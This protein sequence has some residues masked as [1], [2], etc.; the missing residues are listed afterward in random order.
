MNNKLVYTSTDLSI[1][2]QIITGIFGIHGLFQ[3]LEPIHQILKTV[4]GL[5]MIVQ[6]VELFFYIMIIRNLPVS[7][8]AYVRYYDWFFTT[9]A[10]LITT[11]IYF[12]YEQY[13]E[14]FKNSKNSNNSILLKS[15]LS[16]MNLFDFLKENKL[17][18][19]TIVIC[20]FFM[21]L[22]GY[23]GE[24]GAADTFISCVFGFAFF[25]MAFYVIYDKFAKFSKIGNKMFK[26]LFFVWSLYGIA[27]L[28][29][30]IYKN[31]SFNTLDVVSKNFFG[32][33]LYFKILEKK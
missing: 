21:L 32:V 8:M 29:N 33:Y 10:M 15:N 25:L 28:F 6:V 11:V 27:Y 4:L 17:D 22:F 31:I 20:N 24:I 19:S 1:V 9:P 13:I 18:V 14:E 26:L 30:P 2:A 23:L 3:Q 7:N 12:K 16:N 5:E